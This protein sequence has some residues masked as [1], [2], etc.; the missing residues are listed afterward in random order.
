MYE[1]TWNH[2]ISTPRAGFNKCV[3]E[4][5]TQFTQVVCHVL[6]NSTKYP[7]TYT[8][9]YITKDNGLYTIRFMHD[10]EV[11]LKHHY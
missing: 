10:G 3:S 5:C 9:G 11:L 7:F 6:Q 4:R 2:Y 8:G 1:P